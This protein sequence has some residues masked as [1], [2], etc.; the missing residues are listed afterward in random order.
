MNTLK[1]GSGGV[2][3]AVCQKITL[4]R[5]HLLQKEECITSCFNHSVHEMSKPWLL[6]TVS[7]GKEG[8]D[9][10]SCFPCPPLAWRLA[11]LY[12]GVFFAFYLRK[13]L[14]F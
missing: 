3:L 10:S 9:A 14:G 2:Y 13:M 6:L 11:V 4:Q 8:K 7:E 12:L 1:A 5:L